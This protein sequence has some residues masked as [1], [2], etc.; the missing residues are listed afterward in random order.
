MRLHFD[1]EKNHKNNHH[2]ICWFIQKRS[3]IQP[4][5]SPAL[6][7]QDQDNQ[8]VASDAH[9]E[10]ERV[11]H[12]QEDPLEVSSHDVLHA[13]R[14]IKIKF[15]LLGARTRAGVIVVQ[16]EMLEGDVPSQ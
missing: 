3:E 8:A 1:L 5:R 4:V 7:A 11:D 6:A 13:A 10:D 2:I 14:L 15:Q 16:D 9:D 12:R